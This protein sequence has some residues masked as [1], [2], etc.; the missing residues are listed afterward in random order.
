MERIVAI[1]L[2]GKGR[3]RQLLKNR[4][5]SQ[6]LNR[7]V[8]ECLYL[9]PERLGHD[10]NGIYALSYSEGHLQVARHEI[11]ADAIGIGIG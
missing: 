6:T 3:M 7:V 8:A 10:R 4:R 9:L 11:Q 2:Q 5:E 1:G